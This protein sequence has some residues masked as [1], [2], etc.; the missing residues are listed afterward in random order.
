MSN[1]KMLLNRFGHVFAADDSLP[2]RT[3][4]VERHIDLEHGT[5]PFKLSARRI[6][7]HLQAEA[8]KKIQKMLDNAIV[9]PS[10]CEFSSPPVLVRT[11]DGSVR[12]CIDYRKLN[13]KTIKDSYPLPR[14]SEAIDLIGR[15]AKLFTRLDLAMGYHH[16]SIAEKDKHKTAFPS[17]F[18]LLQYTVSP[19]GLTNAP[20]VSTINGTFARA[21]E[22]ERLP[23]LHR[24]RL[25]L[26][27]NIR[28]AS[29]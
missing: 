3:S 1:L 20:A 12:F 18:G 19:F 14:I 9:E 21:H 17:P 8:V 5:R 24:R 23:R 11:N 28:G 13:E 4:L 27:Q 22:L 2:S 26:V 10:N 25:D 29:S 15:D 6:P 16:V 7:I